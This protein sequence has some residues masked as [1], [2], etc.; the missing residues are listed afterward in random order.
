MKEKTKLKFH[1]LTAGI[2]KAYNTSDTR[3]Y[4]TAEPTIEQTLVDKIVESADFLQ[5]IN[6]LTPDEKSGEKILGSA[7]GMLAKR[8]NT[9]DRDR[10][11]L[12][13]LSLGSKGYECHKTEFDYFIKY[14]TIDAWAKFKDFA[15][16]FLNWTRHQT[17]LSQIMVGW[18]G[19]SIAIETDPETNTNGEDVNKGWLQKLREY[20]MDGVVTQVIT[21]GAE[22]SG[23]VRIGKDG[24]Y[25][26]LDAAVHDCLQLLHDVHRERDDLVAIIGRDLLAL[27]KSQLY[28]AQGE[29]PSEKERI[30]NQR[31]TR[32]Y[33]GLPAQSETFFPSRGIW[34]GP[35]SNLSM[36]IQSGSIRQKIEDNAKRDRVEHYHSMN[37]DYVVEDEQA[38]AMIE[39]KNVQL[40]DGSGGWA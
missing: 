8:T 33:G 10:Q 24:D 36:Y 5:K 16:R 22:G 31:V 38:C 17:A 30:E 18:Y 15:N 7:S 19:E 20:E 37:V 9:N 27:D 3:T 14:E 2:A 28:V 1:K 13:P 23:V 26:N 12:N 35:L 34:V 39:F 4:F 40:P 6:V 11:P 32:T 21:E 29:T 25:E